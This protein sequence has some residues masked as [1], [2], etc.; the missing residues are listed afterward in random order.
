[1]K[2]YDY[3]RRWTVAVN[4]ETYENLI[5]ETAKNTAAKLPKGYTKCGK[6]FIVETDKLETARENM[7]KCGYTVILQ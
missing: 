1:M 3:L 5:I 4:L 2:K 6:P 7:A